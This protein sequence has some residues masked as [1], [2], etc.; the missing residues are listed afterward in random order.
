M[1]ALSLGCVFESN[2]GCDDVCLLNFPSKE[3]SRG[4][5]LRFVPILRK[6][7]STSGLICLIS[8]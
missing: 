1:I 6:S 3:C 5:L 7:C 4:F 2:C 8:R